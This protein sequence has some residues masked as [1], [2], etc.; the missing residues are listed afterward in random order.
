MR[1]KPDRCLHLAR[2]DGGLAVVARQ[3]AGL[4]CDLLKDVVDEGVH[5][6][7]NGLVSAQF[8]SSFN[9]A[10]LGLAREPAHLVWAWL[11]EPEVRAM[12]MPAETSRP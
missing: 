12:Y 7:A 3:A 11:F 6:P 4:S 2:R 10:L 1:S 8:E 9:L 5:D